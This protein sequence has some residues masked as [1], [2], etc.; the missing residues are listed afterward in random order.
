M[1]S[2][3]PKYCIS[4]LPESIPTLQSWIPAAEAGDLIE[5]RL[6]QIPDADLKAI[7]ALTG[8]PLIL[9]LRSTREGG[10]WEG[11]P[12]QYQKIC[13]A[14]ID[15]GF[16]YLDVEHDAAEVLAKLNIGNTRIILSRHTHLKQRKEL[17]E[18]LKA[19]LSVPAAVYKLVYN[20]DSLRDNLALFELIETARSAQVD[21]IIHAMGEAGR[22]S[23]II[24]AVRGNAWTY[25]AREYSEATAAGQLAHHEAKEFYF[26][27]QKQPH[28]RLLGL[29]GSPL[30]QSKG[31][32]LHNL[33]IQEKIAGNR[34][35]S[36]AGK[37]FIYMNF[38]TDQFKEFWQN[39]HPHLHGLS[40]TLPHKETVVEYLSEQTPEVRISGACNTVVRSEKGW[41]GYNTDLT[42]METI[43]R[44]HFELLRGGGLVVGTG[45]TARSAIAALKRL[46]VNPIFLVGRNDKRGKLLSEL[47]GVEYLKEGEIHYASASVIIQTTPVGMVPYTDKY[48]PGTALF[49]KNRVVLDV[50]YNPAETRFLKI[51]RERGC[52]TISGMEMF[53]LQ[54]ARQF[55]IFTGESVSREEI[56]DVWQRI[57]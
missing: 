11:T 55:E 49:R 40:V 45:A 27:D 28:A 16:D 25:V 6:D 53:L 42:A 1:S 18:L 34:A 21:Y 22:L 26:L 12:A 38:P 5:I 32:R 37:D 56:R 48:P 17:Q 54:A 39:W 10:H 13:Q 19:M 24:G 4:L 44:P 52:I 47:Y 31:W 50:I 9:T 8:K 2:A 7:R 57:S 36:S 14:A 3:Q 43:L 35:K 15:A 51:A 33:L 29:V 46:E 30:H 41:R 20:A 23:R